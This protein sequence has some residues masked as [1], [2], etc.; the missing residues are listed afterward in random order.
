M[1]SWS[2][3]YDNDS[4]EIDDLDNFHVFVKVPPA[5]VKAS[6]VDVPAMNGSLD[7]TDFSGEPKYENIEAVL[8]LI[9]VSDI[10][11]AKEASDAFVN[12]Y[13]G[14]KVRLINNT[15]DYMIIGRITVAE[16][17]AYTKV[18]CKLSCN[19][20]A[21][22]LKYE[23]GYSPSAQGLN[24]NPQ[25][26]GENL[27]SVSNITSDTTGATVTS[28]GGVISADA[29]DSN[30][31]EYIIPAEVAP[32]GMLLEV[33]MTPSDDCI[34]ESVGG[35]TIRAKN[36]FFYLT[37]G[38][39]TRV[40]IKRTT[41]EAVSFSIVVYSVGYKTIDNAGKSVPAQ[42]SSQAII[43][44]PFGASLYLFLNG[45]LRKLPLE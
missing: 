38:N 45:M 31:A 32:A 25:A 35:S 36:V 39:D 40:V 37:D 41:V 23:L 19:F 7:I 27:W 11:N 13:A 5:M 15:Q 33:Y 14:Q 6:Y 2:I 20:I 18:V 10:D 42:I 28:A 16:Y 1:D 43:L 8:T 12:Q 9:T 26:R 24:I 22:P 34:L 3:Q 30:G 4:A 29:S 17:S 21:N 44:Q